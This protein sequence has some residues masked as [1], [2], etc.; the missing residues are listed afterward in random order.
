MKKSLALLLAVL[1][2]TVCFSGI[3]GKAAGREPEPT[4]YKYYTSIMIE[5]GDT[6]WDIAQEQNDEGIISTEAYITELRRINHLEGDEIRAGQNL[7]VFY[8]DT[9]LK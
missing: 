6:L 9:V 7:T 8:Y 5:S 3:V 1:V 2:F 4:Y